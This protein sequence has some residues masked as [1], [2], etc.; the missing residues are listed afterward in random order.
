MIMISLY[1]YIVTKY[2]TNKFEDFIWGGEYEPAQVAI[3]PSLS[4]SNNGAAIII[5]IASTL[6]LA[7]VGLFFI[8]R[9]KHKEE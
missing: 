7:S 4:I 1:H 2:G 5:A 8:I 9:K 3:L 6:T